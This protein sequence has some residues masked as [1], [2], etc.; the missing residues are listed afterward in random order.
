M[1]LVLWICLSYL[2]GSVPTSYI[3]GKTFASKDLRQLGS[4]NLGATNVYRVLG[5]KYAIPVGLIDITKGI[6]PVSLFARYA[7][8]EPWWCCCVRTRFF[9]L[10]TVSGR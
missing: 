10:R 5:L 2:L 7:G 3:V 6:I 8:T 1:N 9:L 4:K